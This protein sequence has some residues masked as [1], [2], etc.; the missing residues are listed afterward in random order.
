MPEFRAGPVACLVSILISFG[1]AASAITTNSAENRWTTYT[2]LRFGTTADYPADLFTGKSYSYRRE[3]NGFI[4]G[5]AGKDLHVEG[6]SETDL[7]LE[8]RIPR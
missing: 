3:G 7:I 4:L 1:F 5:S 8:W 2:N 6:D